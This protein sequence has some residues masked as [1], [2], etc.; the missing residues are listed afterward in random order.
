MKPS[1]GRIVHFKSPDYE[2]PVAALITAVYHDDRCD[3]T[4]FEPGSF[5]EP[6]S[7]V[8]FSEEPNV[9]MSWSWPPRV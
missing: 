5:P 6:R 2:D 9:A 7:A 4:L 8:P 3:L 1:V